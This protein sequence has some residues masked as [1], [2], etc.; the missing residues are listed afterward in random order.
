MRSSRTNRA[1]GSVA[2]IC[3]LGALLLLGRMAW[4]FSRSGPL[5]GTAGQAVLSIGPLSCLVLFLLLG[6][7]H[8]LCMVATGRT[9]RR[10]VN[11]MLFAFSLLLLSMCLLVVIRGAANLLSAL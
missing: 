8:S 1:L 6:C 11:L 10:L 7:V 9:N 4:V 2:L 5:T 3:Q